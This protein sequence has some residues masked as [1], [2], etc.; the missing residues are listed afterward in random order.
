MFFGLNE[1]PNDCVILLLKHAHHISKV[2]LNCTTSV[3]DSEK[4]SCDQEYYSRQKHFKQ[5]SDRGKN[6]HTLMK[7][8]SVWSNTS[9]KSKES[10]NY[11][12]LVPFTDNNNN[13]IIIGRDDDY[14][15]GAR[16]LIGRTNN[17]LLFITYLGNNISV[18]DL[19]TFRF[20]K[21]DTLPTMNTILFHCF[22]SNSENGKRQEMIKTNK[23]NYQMLFQFHQL[24]TYENI[25]SFH[26][27]AYVCINGVILFFGGWNINNGVCSKSVYKYSIRENKWTTFQ[28]TLPS[29]L[30]DC[31]AILS[32]D[33]KYVHIIGGLNNEDKP[34]LT[35]VKIEVSEWLSKE[36]LKVEEDEEKEN[37]EEEEK[38][39]NSEMNKLV[40]KKD[41]K[42]NLNK[43]MKWWNERE[44][45]DKTKIIEKFKTLSNEKFGVWL[46][47]EH[48]WKNEITK[49][50]I[51]F[52]CFSI[53]SYLSLITNNEDIKEEKELT[54]YV[55]VNERET[56]IK[57]K[58][59]TFEELLR[60]SYYCLEWKDI[61]KMRNEH[62][63]LDLNNMKDNMIESDNDVKREF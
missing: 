14:Y 40:K 55:K 12:R 4:L 35:Q 26:R 30:Y 60:Q 49:D 31:V 58:E 17:N 2:N 32:E 24:H 50:D 34:V 45:K 51:D 47:N 23:Q 25:E 57:M 19:N 41:V 62:I 38:D 3:G 43:V 28:N 44:Q 36:E 8:V 52:I 22:V 10:N 42:E 6:R 46:L 9:N 11:N 48:K 59:L 53:D 16:A 56:L 54:T 20:I 63:K 13:P 7:Y 33:N 18:F 5:V 27:Y 21:H 15:F 37:E 1:I 29:P 39:S 61:Q